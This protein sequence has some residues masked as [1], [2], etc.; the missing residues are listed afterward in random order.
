MGQPTTTEEN[1]GGLLTQ[2]DWRRTLSEHELTD[3]LENQDDGVLINLLHDDL[4]ILHDGDLRG[5]L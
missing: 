3:Q 1:L 2:I 4:P 5:Y